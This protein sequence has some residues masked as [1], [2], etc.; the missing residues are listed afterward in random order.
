MRELRE[1]PLDLIDVPKQEMRTAVAREKLDLLVDSIR[2]IGIRQP[3]EVREKE[4]RYEIVIGVRRYLAAKE[5]SLATVPA[6]VITDDDNAARIATVHE[7]LVREDVDPV[8]LGYYL[9]QVKNERGMTLEEVGAYFGYSKGWADQY[10][11]LTRV[12]PEIKQAVSDGH[13]DITSARRL[14]SVKDVE[15]RKIMLMHAVQD[16]A[17]QRTLNSW[18]TAAEVEQ[19]TRPAYPP[20]SGAVPSREPVPADLTFTCAWCNNAAST[21]DMVVMR[22]CVPCYEM[23]RNAIE[24]ER[25]K[26]NGTVI[27]EGT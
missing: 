12:D 24:I 15:R 25:S 23:I 21:S 7:N 22:F 9:L 17:S 18:I 3:L 16:G 13:I 27:P 1:I 8:D 14:M 2:Q 26:T 20:V 5:L 6:F 19:G 4:G 10:I 11:A